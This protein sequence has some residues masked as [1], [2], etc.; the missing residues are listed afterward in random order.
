VQSGYFVQILLDLFPKLHDR[1][2]PRRTSKKG[3]MRACIRTG[4]REHAILHGAQREAPCCLT[5]QWPA[6]P[7]AAVGGS[8][9]ASL[10]LECTPGVSRRESV[11]VRTGARAHALQRDGAGSTESARPQRLP[12]RE[13]GDLFDGSH[14]RAALPRLAPR[15]ALRRR[16]GPHA[17]TLAQRRA[18]YGEPPLCLE[19]ARGAA[20]I[21]R[22][23]AFVELA[24]LPELSLLQDLCARAPGS[25]ASRGAG[26]AGAWGACSRRAPGAPPGI[27]CSGPR[28]RRPTCVLACDAPPLLSRPPPARPA[29]R[30][31]RI[32][33]RD[34]SG[35]EAKQSSPGRRH[36]QLERPRGL[37]EDEC[38]PAPARPRAHRLPLACAPL[39]GPSPA[40]T[41]ALI[42]I[43][44]ACARTR[45]RAAHQMCT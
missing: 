11:Q 1:G 26:G 22:C 8:V 6:S 45:T 21:G 18:R 24:E 4:R 28:R 44:V 35:R 17:A 31:V 23:C 20:A 29:A 37:Q 7:P 15:R 38:V 41:L 39:P 2:R 5:L 10:M 12:G 43:A 9:P 36:G 30:W 19:R 27:S 16:H 32:C 42:G 33:V 3:T 13:R 40:L 34:L 25:A 14:A